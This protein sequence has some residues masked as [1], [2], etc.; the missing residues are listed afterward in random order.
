[1][2]ESI[3]CGPTT[4]GENTVL[5]SVLHLMACMKGV[6]NFRPQLWDPNKAFSHSF[7]WKEPIEQMAI[8]IS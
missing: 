3:V 1:M 7:M 5:D 4:S 8:D 2:T 6:T